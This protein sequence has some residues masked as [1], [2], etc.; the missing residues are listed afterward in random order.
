MGG[1][2]DYREDGYLFL[3]RTDAERAQ[4]ER[5]ITLQNS[6]GVPSR[7]IDPEE[8]AAI[9]PGM[10]VDDLAGAAY[11]ASDGAAG[12]NEATMA[13]ARAAR[14]R[15]ARI[16]QGA[17]VIAIDMPRNR[18]Y[19]VRTAHESWSAPVV[20]IAAGPWAGLVAALAGVDVPIKPIR[21]E[22]FVSEPF[23]EL[24]DRLPIVIDLHVGWYFRREG[25][26]IL[27]SGHKDDHASFDTHVDWDAL[28]EVA[29]LAMHRVPALE[30][31]SFGARAWSGLY[32]VSP[33]D[34]AI[35]GEV[36]GVPGLYLACGFSGHGFQHSPATGRLMAELILEGGTTGI[37]IEPLGL[38]R[39]ARGTTL[40][41]PLTAHAGT[42]GG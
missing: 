9:V 42:I 36:Q 11:N 31:A 37:D 34:H 24:P 35:L 25:A 26:G 4:F 38:G 2:V 15:G 39:F 14:E 30:R 18:V 28:S 3:A 16:V 12:P 29:D 1:P 27:M 40:R 6:L 10:R 23:A 20:V 32:D 19:T 21:R 41:E 13:F 7:L 22:I 5:N 33:D 17:D 8:A